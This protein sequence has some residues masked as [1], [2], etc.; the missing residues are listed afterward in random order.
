MEKLL[1]AFKLIF[2]SGIFNSLE[3]LLKITTCYKHDILHVTLYPF[4]V[5]MWC[6]AICTATMCSNFT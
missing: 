4:S 1:V 2:L 3:I 6:F 5:K